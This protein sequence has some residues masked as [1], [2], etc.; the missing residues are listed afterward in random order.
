MFSM[1]LCFDFGKTQC[2]DNIE[3]QAEST[4]TSQAAA[5]HTV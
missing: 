1:K 4:D 3:A 2:M 5:A